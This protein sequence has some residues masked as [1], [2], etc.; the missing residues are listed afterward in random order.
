MRELATPRFK[1][2]TIRQS[3]GLRNLRERAVGR[4][5]FEF[6]LS[7]VNFL[8]GA[9]FQA[10][11]RTEALTKTNRRRVRAESVGSGSISGGDAA[12]AV[13]SVRETR[14]DC[15]RREALI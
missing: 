5:V 11:R 13:V 10:S 15:S 1:S 2:A 9:I 3:R 6:Q 8:P 12:T 7:A 14:R 4:E